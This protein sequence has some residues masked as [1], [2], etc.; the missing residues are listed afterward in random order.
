MRNFK[1]YRRI[2]LATLTL[3]GL[4]SLQAEATII[5]NGSAGI[6]HPATNTILDLTGP[7]FPQFSDVQI[8][9]GKT[10]KVLSGTSGSTAQF[11]AQN[12][13][14]LNGVIDAS[15]S[16]LTISAGN[17]I[18]LGPSSQINTGSLSLYINPGNI[19]S[20]TGQFPIRP[21][22]GGSV[23]LWR[24]FDTSTGSAIS[25]LQS[26]D[27]T[28][29]LHRI[30]GGSIAL[31]SGSGISNSNGLSGGILT[32]IQPSLNVPEPKTIFLFITGLFLLTYRRKWPA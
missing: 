14:M 32:I 29:V 6:F 17:S 28:A 3:A 18:V 22:A 13:F 26:P 9:T 5:S 16:L 8:D 20:L 11:L 1:Q 10:V 19:D 4:I 7:N 30:S 31:T 24:N 25:I 2:F 21:P 12:N 27:S 15:D 23:S